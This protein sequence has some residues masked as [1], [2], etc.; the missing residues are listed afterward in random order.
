MESNET[1]VQPI[2]VG[3]RI[4]RPF[5]IL[6]VCNNPGMTVSIDGERTT[7]IAQTTRV[8]EQLLTI[9]QNA[10]FPILFE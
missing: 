9:L 5:S 1:S 10:G 3:Q 2:E 7:I 6:G 4:I 8:R